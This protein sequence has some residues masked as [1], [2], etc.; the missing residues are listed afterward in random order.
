[1]PSLSLTDE[2]KLLPLMRLRELLRTVTLDGTGLSEA[3]DPERGDPCLED[4]SDG[5][6]SLDLAD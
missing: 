1:M 2:P 4:V 3:I 5:A 6:G